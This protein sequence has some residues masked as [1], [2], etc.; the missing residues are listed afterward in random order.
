[1]LHIPAV[2][3]FISSFANGPGTRVQSQIVSY[4]R[5]K[6]WYFISHGLTLSIIRYVSRVKWRNPRKG[7]AP[8]PTPWCSSYWKGKLWVDLDYSRQLTYIFLYD[9]ALHFLKQCKLCKQEIITLEICFYVIMY[10][11]MK[12]IGTVLFL[13]VFLRRYGVSSNHFCHTKQFISLKRIT[14]TKCFHGEISTDL[15]RKKDRKKEKKWRI[16]IDIY[17]VTEFEKLT[18]LYNMGK[19]SFEFG[20]PHVLFFFSSKI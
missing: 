20:L 19:R 13:N 10:V 7:V 2:V 5:L 9:V 15:Q 18:F 8:F 1:M 11:F 6:K 14:V 4:Q 16:L 17:I 12:S 3:I